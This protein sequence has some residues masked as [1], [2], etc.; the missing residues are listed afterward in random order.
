[1]NV[2]DLIWII[3]LSDPRDS[4]S[5]SEGTIYEI[6]LLFPFI[7]PSILFFFRYRGLKKV[8]IPRKVD[9]AVLKQRLDIAERN[10][11]RAGKGQDLIV[12]SALIMLLSSIYF[13][14]DPEHHYDYDSFLG[15]F[16][17]PLSV[18]TLII[19]TLII[20]FDDNSEQ[21]KVN[22]IKELIRK[23]SWKSYDDYDWETLIKHESRLKNLLVAELDKYL[24]HHSLNHMK[25]KIKSE[26]IRTIR[27]HWY[28]HLESDLTS[29][30]E[31]FEGEI[32]IRRPNG[33]MINLENLTAEEYLA[34]MITRNPEK[35]PPERLTRL[36]KER[37]LSEDFI[38]LS[39]EL[40][41]DKKRENVSQLITILNVWKEA[42]SITE[43][44]YEE[45]REN[46]EKV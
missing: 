32:R 12:K 20:I 24:E 3:L 8:E 22:N 19:L 13:V 28:K 31:K 16:G 43:Q 1:M 2:D 10:L 17:L 41:N 40:K 25:K 4:E 45:A 29:S 11:T 14:I 35:F 44:E 18:A 34:D 26:K 37:S 6:F 36:K 27:G 33:Q 46:I 5:M 38:R 39:L 15:S 30:S 21:E 23:K 42:G 9:A 7:F